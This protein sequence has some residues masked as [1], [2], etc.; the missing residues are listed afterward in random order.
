MTLIRRFVYGLPKGQ[1]RPRA[2]ARK[3]GGSVVARVY[4]A[5]TAEGWKG[6]IANDFKRTPGLA[7]IDGALR[8]SI[9]FYFPR[10]LRLSRKSDA[11]GAIPCTAKPDADN[12]AKAVMD[13]LQGIGLFRDDAQIVELQVRKWYHAKNR[14]PGALIEV[15]DWLTVGDAVAAVGGTIESVEAS[16]A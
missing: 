13:A 5:G 15:S 2:F 6:A 12:A 7:P 1:P 16:Q 8:M 11:P 14:R 3:I 9:D 4:D 10:P